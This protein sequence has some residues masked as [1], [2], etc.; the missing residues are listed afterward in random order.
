MSPSFLLGAFT[1]FSKYKAREIP[2][3]FIL[4]RCSGCSKGL[5]KNS[6]GGSLALLELDVELGLR[7]L[8]DA[9]LLVLQSP[10]SLRPLHYR[11]SSGLRYR[12]NP[13]IRILRA[14]SSNSY[15]WKSG[16]N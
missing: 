12:L 11:E 16:T 4:A 8:D 14:I 7:T 2:L 13:R 15:V 10:L 9:R 3:S 5:S 1:T 6:F